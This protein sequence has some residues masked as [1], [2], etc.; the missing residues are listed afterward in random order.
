MIPTGTLLYNP[1]V[2][3]LAEVVGAPSDVCAIIKRGR[4]GTRAYDWF[5]GD[6]LH[7]LPGDVAHSELPTTIGVASYLCS[8]EITLHW[9]PNETA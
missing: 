9:E 5:E 4:G 7:V 6:V 3:E 1:R 8:S 2:Y